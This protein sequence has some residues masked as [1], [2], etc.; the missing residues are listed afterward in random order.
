MSHNTQ[1]HSGF[2]PPTGTWHNPGEATN[3][4]S[5]GSFPAKTFYAQPRST[6]EIDI[7][8][9]IDLLANEDPRVDA[10]LS[11]GVKWVASAFSSGQ[12]KNLKQIRR[13]AG[14]TQ[15]T[16]AKKI[17][18]S[19]AHICNIEKGQVCPGFD[20]VDRLA[21]ALSVSPLEILKLSY[22]AY[23]ENVKTD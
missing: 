10:V 9:F 19:Q 12:E 2:W 16:L 18:S 4:S 8:D 14:Y 6:K 22:L 7:D 20:L 3:H 17:N 13:Q 1:L 11:E 23:K 15:S 21:E 5:T